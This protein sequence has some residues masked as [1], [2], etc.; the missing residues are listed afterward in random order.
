[1]LTFGLLQGK[2]TG[3][4]CVVQILSEVIA[5]VNNFLSTGSRDHQPSVAAA[6]QPCTR[7][8]PYIESRYSIN[9][10]KQ[11]LN[12]YLLSIVYNFILYI[13]LCTI[14]FKYLKQNIF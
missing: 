14:K 7:T 1:M 10:S 5:I 6:T 3:I 8:H 4:S 2:K 12:T 13:F 9:P 11:V